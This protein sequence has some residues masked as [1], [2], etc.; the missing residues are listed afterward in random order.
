MIKSVNDVQHASVVTAHHLRP[1]AKWL[2]VVS[3]LDAKFG[4]LSAA[5]PRLASAVAESSEI[6]TS[7]AAF[8]EPGEMYPEFKRVKVSEWPA[9]RTSWFKDRGLTHRFEALAREVDGIHVHGLWQ[10]STYLAART[11]RRRRLPYV[12]S[13]HG[14]LEPWA[15]KNKGVKKALYS[16]FVERAN[17]GEANC[18]HALTLAEAED[19][20]HFGAKGPI[21]VIPNGV[22]AP[23]TLSSRPFLEQFPLLEGRRI[24]LF[25]GR[26]H[27]KKGMDILIE[28]WKGV[29]KEHRDTHLVIAG[30]DF[31]GTRAA[32]EA[33]VTAAGVEDRVL[34]TGMLDGE[35]KWS[36][37]VAAECFVLPSYSEGLSVSVLEAMGA[38]VPVIISEQCHLPEVAKHDAGLVIRADAADLRAALMQ[39]LDN[40]ETTNRAIGER[41]RQL[42][43][44]RYEWSS[45]AR[46]MREVYTWVGGGERPSAVEIVDGRAA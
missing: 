23:T 2:Q 37:L 18:L 39:M 42:V 26:I 8:C 29:S 35:M 19:Y 17:V 44:S 11:A 15:L 10:Q 16:R 45:I 33:Q 7:L 28:A 5:V 20:R 34:F 40:S 14:M 21:V 46:Q 32:I 12:L 27:F 9:G 24:V 13:A 43:V 41:G 30:P 22:D 4:G 3:H 6:S 38:G 36:A 25:L 1:Q 31:E